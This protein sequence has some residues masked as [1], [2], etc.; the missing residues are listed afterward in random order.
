[1]EKREGFFTGL[2]IGVV[3][4]FIMGV[5]LRP[6]RRGGFG[7]IMRFIEEG[8]EAIR[9]AIEEGREAARRREEDIRTRFGEEA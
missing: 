3:I 7:F 9:Q 8:K 1:M 2:I 5:L 6:G 4:G